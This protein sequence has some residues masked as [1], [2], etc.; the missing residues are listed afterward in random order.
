M[1]TRETLSPTEDR[2]LTPGLDGYRGCT[3]SPIMCA[4]CASPEGDLRPV[5]IGTFSLGQ[6]NIPQTPSANI[7][8]VQE[9]K[10]SPWPN[11]ARRQLY[12]RDHQSLRTAIRLHPARR[13]PARE[14]R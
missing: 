7:G 9:I 6:F 13:R 5:G 3:G 2:H 1:P 14:S 10:G 8:G 4:P 11:A 12:G